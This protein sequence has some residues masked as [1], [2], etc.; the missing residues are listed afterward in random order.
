MKRNLFAFVFICI[1]FHSKAQILHLSIIDD[2]GSVLDCNVVKNDSL[3][4]N[5][6][7]YYVLSVQKGDK[8]ILKHSWYRDTSFQITEVLTPSD[9]LIKIIQLKQKVKQIDEVIISGEKYQLLY[10]ASNE[11]VID[12]YPIP[13]N[14]ILVL[15]KIGKNRFL[16]ML[17]E[18]NKPE[19][20]IPLSINPTELFLDA[21]GNFHILTKDSVYQLHLS[22][23]LLLLKGISLEVF[24]KNISNLLAVDQNAFYQNY[25]EHNQLFTIETLSGQNGRKEIYR[26][27][28]K[29][30]YDGAKYTSNKMI[31]Y[32]IDSV[33][34]WRNVILLGIWNGNL[35][36]L[37][38]PLYPKLVEMYGW[39]K[40]VMSL[41]LKVSAFGM[42]DNLVI[43]DNV[44]NSILQLN[45][46]TFEI[47]H[48]AVP[49]FDLS[50]HFYFDYFYDALY[51]YIVKK[52]ITDIFKVDIDTGEAISIAQLTDVLLPR[53]IKISNNWTYFTVL[54]SDGYNKLLKVRR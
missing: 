38:D 51:T 26:T 23:T 13:K 19:Q 14:K 17:D 24:Q 4:G 11:F 44:K 31:R 5:N 29:V 25:S 50:R 41:P 30:G 40:G 54:D 34:E 15:S 16:K 2:I 32:Y 48:T 27:F 1:A 53:N 49:K 10:E 33:P 37:I 21:M 9:T 35:F 6:Q 18:N 43:L 45:Y 8:F 22:D 47:V 3:I 12:Y 7:H 39:Y 36:E 28:D 52:G 42:L 20:E 46:E